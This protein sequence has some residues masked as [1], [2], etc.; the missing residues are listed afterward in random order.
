MFVKSKT[1]YLAEITGF[2]DAQYHRFQ[3]TVESP[4]QCFGRDFGKIPWTDSALHRFQNGILTDALQ[5]T[6]HQSVVDLVL[7]MLQPMS[8][9]IDDVVGISRIYL[10]HMIQPW[11]GL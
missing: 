9:T 7:G 1:I 4:N 10:K 11:L 3:E 8:Q 6:Q 5:S 2:I